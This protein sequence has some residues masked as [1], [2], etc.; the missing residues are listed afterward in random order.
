MPILHLAIEIKAFEHV[1]KLVDAINAVDAKVVDATYHCCESIGT[2]KP[3]PAR[4]SGRKLSTLSTAILDW[5]NRNPG[6]HQTC[7]V[8]YGLFPEA[9]AKTVECVSARMNVLAKGGYVQRVRYG[10]YELAT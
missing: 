9:D 1:A 8:A 6:Q 5:M 10:V 7:A 4:K 2:T 3:I